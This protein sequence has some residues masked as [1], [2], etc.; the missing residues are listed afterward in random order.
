L[1]VDIM[2]PLPQTEERNKY[3]VGIAD[4]FTKSTVA[5]AL[6]NQEAKNCCQNPGGGGNMQ[7]RSTSSVAF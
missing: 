2:G 4:Y 5:F 7:I 6:P 3:I 1:A